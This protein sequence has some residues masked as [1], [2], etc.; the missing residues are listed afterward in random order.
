MHG[1]YIQILA[2]ILFHIIIRG[3]LGGSVVKNL[4]DNAGDL[5]SIPGLGRSP[6]EGNGNPLQYYCLGNPLD[7][8]DWWTIVQGVPKQSD[9]AERLNTCYLI[10][11]RML[12]VRM[13]PLAC[14]TP[15]RRCDP[16]SIQSWLE[17]VKCLFWAVNR[18]CWSST[19]KS[20]DLQES[21]MC[22]VRFTRALFRAG[23]DIV[24]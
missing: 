4:P 16:M 21:L 1:I 24:L 19:T 10:I 3:F 7:R 5:S 6:R 13:V 23:H 14:R 17:A 12:A 20:F 2:F 15:M 22:L 8:G 9:S 18:E 11:A